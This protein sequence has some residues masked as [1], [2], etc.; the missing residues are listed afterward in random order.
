MAL[1]R[2]RACA[3]SLILRTQHSFS[4]SHASPV[5]SLHRLL[6]SVAAAASSA[7]S[8]RS[9]AVEDYLVSRCGVTRA[10]ALKAAKKIP[11]LSSHSKPD[12]V[13]AF[14]GGTLGVPAGDIAAAVAM[15]PRF[16]A[17]NVERTIEPRIAEISNLGLSRDEI[18]RLIPLAPCFFHSRFLSR[19]LEFW[20]NELGSFDKILQALRMNSSMLAVDPDK[21]AIPNMAFL[22]Q[23][24]LNASDL[25][26]CSIYSPRLFS[27][28]PEHLRE[29]VKRV[30]ELGVERGTRMFARTLVLISLRSKEAVTSRMQLLQ[31]FGF[32][33]DDVREI[34]R[35]A[36]PV[37][38][39]S[40]QKVQGN[41]D[42]LM[43]DVG[44]D[45]S[46]IAR[47]PVLILYSLE[48]RLLPRH[49]LLKVLKEKGLLT[50]EFDYYATASM[51][52]KLFLQKFVLPY[53]DVVP[54]LAE[55]YASKCSV[56]AVHRVS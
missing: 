53:K 55:D 44:L 3:L 25:L 43:K 9:F 27:M 37:L 23:C 31:K 39:L 45:A 15:D 26:A 29:A 48:R 42:F 19:N 40:D 41:V 7:S 4:A 10:Q 47:R 56:K 13:L 18:A 50:F 2:S 17:A 6:C 8:S 22:R 28:N 5:V 54:G 20:L 1:H 11:Y 52:E 33:Q 35:K 49:W 24:G 46:Y 12:A 14:L 32:S 16:L 51:G 34:V 36:P 21:M 38:G 30:E